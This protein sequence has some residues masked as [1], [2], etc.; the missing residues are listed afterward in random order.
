[1]ILWNT[2]EV[3]ARKEIQQTKWLLSMHEIRFPEPMGKCHVWWHKY[4]TSVLEVEMEK[5][6][7]VFIL[8][9]MCELISTH[10]H[11]TKYVAK[12]STLT[13]FYKFTEFSQW[14]IIFKKPY[15][16]EFKDIFNYVTVLESNWWWGEVVRARLDI[17]LWSRILNGR[18]FKILSNSETP[19]LSSDNHTISG[20]CPVTCL[21]I[22]L[23][24]IHNNGKSI[25]FLKCHDKLIS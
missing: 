3:W 4:L 5:P 9:Y 13:F 21:L 10:I 8:V 12:Y 15:F 17:C 6:S 7:W 25:I 2:K 19:W 1:M 16:S 23:P 11:I 22:F 24:V 20:S 14:V 18:T